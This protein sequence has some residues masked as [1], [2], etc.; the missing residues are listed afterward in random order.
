MDDKLSLESIARYRSNRDMA[1]TRRARRVWGRK[2]NDKSKGEKR[3]RE[4]TKEH[5]RK[6]TPVVSFD[7]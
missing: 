2:G 5:R 6:A 1:L 7:C 3:Q 4:E